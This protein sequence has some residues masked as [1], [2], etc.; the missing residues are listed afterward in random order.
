MKIA[1]ILLGF[2]N[3]ENK[4]FLAI[5]NRLSNITDCSEHQWD[6]KLDQLLIVIQQ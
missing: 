2:G 6:L 5:L 1:Y 3:A 4:L